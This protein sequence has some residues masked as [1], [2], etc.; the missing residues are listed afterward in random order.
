MDDSL[1]NG[2]YIHYPFGERLAMLMFSRATAHSERK[3]EPVTV[4]SRSNV[5]QGW[6]TFQ[7]RQTI[8]KM[9]ST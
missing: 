9:I 8:S 4:Y 7:K 5:P 3:R 2:L 1:R 6:L